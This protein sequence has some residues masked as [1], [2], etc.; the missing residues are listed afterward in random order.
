MGHHLFS[1]ALTSSS[2]GTSFTTSLSLSLLIHPILLLFFY[3]FITYLFITTAYESS[4]HYICNYL[5]FILP[6]VSQ[7]SYSLHFVFILRLSFSSFSFNSFPSCIYSVFS[8]TS[9]YLLIFPHT[10]FTIPSSFLFTFF[11]LL[12][13][14]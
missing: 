7:I 1:S 10:L 11:V 12:I 3:L 2:Y 5:I 4:S 13:F 6:R 14:P 9:F 8:L